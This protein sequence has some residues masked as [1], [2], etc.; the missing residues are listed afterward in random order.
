MND[1]A[2]PD[3]TERN[4][5]IE[6]P[7]QAEPTEQ[8]QQ[9]KKPKMCKLAVLSIVCIVTAFAVL[10]MYLF[11]SEA[12][13]P[14]E[15]ENLLMP[16]G[17]AILAVALVAGVIALVMIKASGGALSGRRLALLG[18]IIPIVAVVAFFRS[19][20]PAEE[21]QVLPSSQ[22]KSNITR[23]AEMLSEYRSDNDGRFPN[24][25]KWCD[26]LLEQ[27]KDESL[28]ACPL[29]EGARCS[30]A[31]NKYAVEAGADL[32]AS[33]VLLF[34]SEPGWNQVA[35]PELMITPHV[36]RGGSRGN[37]FFVGGRAR[38]VSEDGFEELNWKGVRDTEEEEDED[39]EKEEEE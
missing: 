9:S 12:S 18:I 24:P 17:V 23:L 27:A 15:L 39:E 6:E 28:F 20:T 36:S 38:S 3:E 22:C 16:A 4:E 26:I 32:S 31:L 21:S 29:A 5:Q 7:Q 34:E 10:A 13:I 14:L 11:S 37:V 25:E 35:G 2:K 19:K 33:M 30:Y 1:E 8:A